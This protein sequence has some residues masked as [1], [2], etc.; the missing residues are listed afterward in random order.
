MLWDKTALEPIRLVSQKRGL[1]LALTQCSHLMD[2]LARAMDLARFDVI[3]VDDE[4]AC[5]AQ[6]ATSKPDIVFVDERRV[7]NTGHFHSRVNQARVTESLPLLPIRQKGN[8]GLSALSLHQDSLETE[9][10][11]KTRALLRHDRHVALRGDRRSGSFILEEPR[12]K[13]HFN[14]KSVDLSK[15]ELCLLGPFFDIDDAVFDRDSLEQLAFPESARKVGSR[16]VD[17]KISRIRRRLKAQLG[18]DP[19]RSVRGVGY[20]LAKL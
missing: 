15:I 11:L 13:L 5:L 6:I 18:V 12:F 1:A 19:L 14:D 2:T 17:F 20:A 16:I 3:R 8:A 9:I 7:V 10:F 4:A